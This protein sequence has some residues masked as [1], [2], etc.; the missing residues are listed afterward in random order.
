FGIA[1]GVGGVIS[2]AIQIIQITVH[3]GLDW[4]D[5]PADAKSF[6]AELQALKTV[7]SETYT[8]INFN[9]DFA[10]AFHSR[11]SALLSQLGPLA[12][13]TDTMSMVSACEAE[14]KK[15]P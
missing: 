4:K 9:K 12:H 13:G 5:A 7:L 8:N 11:Y 10:D 3:F 14:L 15:T 6:A 2:L 1:A